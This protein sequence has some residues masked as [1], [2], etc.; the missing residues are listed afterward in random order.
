[1]NSHAGGGA[2][3]AYQICR[4]AHERRAVAPPLALGRR[5]EPADLDHVRGPV[6]EHTFDRVRHFADELY[7]TLDR[8][9]ASAGH[10]RPAKALVTG[11]LLLFGAQPGGGGVHE[12]GRELAENAVLV[13]RVAPARREWW[14]C[15]SG[16]W[17]V[18]A[19]LSGAYRSMKASPWLAVHTIFSCTF[20]AKSS[21]TSALLAA[22]RYLVSLGLS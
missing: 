1:M 13:L 22:L 17:C 21:C 11:L 18:G 9:S 5:G 2:A 4:D 3:G 7:D 15:M 16:R 8:E 14:A 19:G 10:Q 6:A 12:T 20:L